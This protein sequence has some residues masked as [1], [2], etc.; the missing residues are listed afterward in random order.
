MHLLKLVLITFILII[1]PL[2]LGWCDSANTVQNLIPASIAPLSIKGLN[3]IWAWKDLTVPAQLISLL[4]DYLPYS[5]SFEQSV[6]QL[7]GLSLAS[8]RPMEA[9]A[10]GLDLKRGLVLM[11]GDRG[12]WRLLIAF[13]PQKADLAMSELRAMLRFLKPTSARQM[14]CAPRAPT[15]TRGGGGWLVCDTPQVQEAPPPTWLSSDLEHGALWAYIPAPVLASDLLP[16]EL[17]PRSKKITALWN[18]AEFHLSLEGDE[19]S[20]SI[21]M[22]APYHPIVSL[23]N[24]IESNEELL[25]WVHPS[26]P[27]DIAFQLTTHDLALFEP[28]QEHFPWIPILMAWVK[29]GWDGRILLT[30]D[31]GLDHPIL[32]IGL[33]EHPWAWEQLTA[34]LAQSI[35]AEF[36]HNPESDDASLLL[37]QGDQHW[38]LPVGRVTS[39]LLLGLYPADLKRRT[40][41]LFSASPG[42]HLKPLLEPGVSG[43]FFDPSVL[44]A[45]DRRLDISLLIPV[46]NAIVSGQFSGLVDLPH[47]GTMPIPLSDSLARHSELR[48]DPLLRWIGERS[49]PSPQAI[50][51]LLLS[52]HE[53]VRLSLLVT[54]GV[55]FT[56]RSYLGTL[57]RLRAEFRWRL[58]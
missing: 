35:G 1:T 52:F 30:F 15:V 3:G 26:S 58:L 23:L 19:L 55:T 49:T 39:H 29:A 9:R 34:H 8:W 12:A 27:L 51:P 11:R 31:G 46:L 16:F 44:S 5:A 41:G 28:F 36:I 2:R 25:S 40:S 20:T 10:E 33:Q 37:G 38:S 21:E 42:T 54:E 18:S 45:H 43:G 13:R 53:F 47:D 50:L 7:S 48:R 57:S 56:L 22:K 6:R 32:I 17:I 24:S 4:R 14:S